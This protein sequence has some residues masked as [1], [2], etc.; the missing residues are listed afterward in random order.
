MP[1]AH[2]TKKSRGV[3]LLLVDVINAFE[4][5]GSGPLAKA[6]ARQAPRIRRLTMRAREAGVPVIYVN[7]NFGQWRS[8]FH[9]IVDACSRPG[10]PGASTSEMLRPTGSDYFVLKPQHSG[11]YSTRWI[12]SWRT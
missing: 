2:A 9:A 5:E 8:D 4:F 11:F 12:Y 7:D 6:A 3:A 10:R 1:R